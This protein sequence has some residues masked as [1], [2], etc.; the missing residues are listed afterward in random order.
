MGHPEKI[1]RRFIR[2]KFFGTALYT[3]IFF[4]AAKPPQKRISA[5]IACPGCF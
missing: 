5:T 3:A 4:A 2:G 1:C